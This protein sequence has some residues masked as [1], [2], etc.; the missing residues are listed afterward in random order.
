MPGGRLPRKAFDRLL[1][2]AAERQRQLSMGIANIEKPAQSP[3]SRR[4][5]LPG[6]VKWLR[7]AGGAAELF[8]W[9]GLVLADWFWVGV[10]A[11]YL[12][13]ALLAL[14]V[15]FEPDRK[16]KTIIGVA[17]LVFTVAFSW[18]VVFVEGPLPINVFATDGEYPIGTVISGVSWRPQFTE[19]NVDIENPK[20]RPYEDL[21][22]VIRPTSAVAV[23]AQTS[24][25]SDVSFEDK[26][27]LSTH[28]LDLDPRTGISKAIPLVLL[29]T[30]AGYRVR[31]GRLP[32]RDHLR[33]VMAL[34]D[35]KWDPSPLPTGTPIEQSFQDPNYMLR[36]KNDDFS[37]YWLGYREGSV[38]ASRP[39]STEWLKVEGDYTVGHR[40]RTV[41]LKV[42]IGGKITLKR[43]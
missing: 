22:L 26:N 38:Y 15:W 36:I 33:I 8:G 10:A 14:D 24:G 28:I 35:I 1:Q 3:K 32:A 11:I 42:Q 29:A 19:L 13:F 4:K 23:L 7:T 43:P 5:K 12:G 34:A 31:C 27:G 9:G 41:S 21:N 25:I 40:R 6:I 37:T 18:G 2:S 39:T 30:D 17:I 16:T 20:D